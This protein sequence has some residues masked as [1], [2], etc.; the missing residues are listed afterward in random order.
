[1]TLVQTSPEVFLAE[2]AIAAVGPDEL[3][4]LK[5]AL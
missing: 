4:T 2:G 1:M 5:A 3:A